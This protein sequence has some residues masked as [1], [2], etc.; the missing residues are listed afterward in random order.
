MAGVALT[1]LLILDKLLF[2]Y[3]WGN[4]TVRVI[5]TATERLQLDGCKYEPQK[6]PSVAENQETIMS[7]GISCRGIPC[8]PYPAKV[9]EWGG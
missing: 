2:S 4:E 3:R 1:K 5:V 8:T 6:L 7:L 9:V